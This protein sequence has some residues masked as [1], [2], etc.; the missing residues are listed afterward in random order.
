MK[1]CFDDDKKDDKKD[2][3]KDKGPSPF[4]VGKKFG[5]KDAKEEEDK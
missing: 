5:E 3:D 1:V 2:D 4:E